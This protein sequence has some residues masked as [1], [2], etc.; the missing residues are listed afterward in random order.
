ME[1]VAHGSLLTIDPDL[2]KMLRKFN[3]RPDRLQKTID[4]VEEND[5][6]DTQKMAIFYLFNFNFEDGW[7]SWMPFPN[8]EPIRQE[9]TN[10]TGLRASDTYKGQVR[11]VEEDE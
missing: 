11:K 5:I 1:K 7:K 9:L 8:A 6:Q 3:I 10:L 2:V 4:W